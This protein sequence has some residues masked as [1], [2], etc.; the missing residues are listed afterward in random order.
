MNFNQQNLVNDRSATE[1]HTDSSQDSLDT[2]E[3]KSAE[4]EENNVDADAP[5]EKSK[6]ESTEGESDHKPDKIDKKKDVND[7]S[8]EETV[9]D[10]TIQENNVEPVNEEEEKSEDPKIETKSSEP[11]DKAD[12]EKEEDEKVS[13]ASE[14]TEEEEEDVIDEDDEGSDKDEKSSNGK[15]AVPLLDQPLETSGKRE[16]KNVQRFEEDFKANDKDSGKLEIDEG[17]GTALGEIPRIEASIVRFKNE[18]L[19]ILHRILFKTE[20]KT[21]LLKKNIKKFNGFVFKKDS[22][23]YKKKVDACKKLEVKSLKSLCEML[24]LEKKG[25]KDD[26][27]ERILDFLLEPKDSGKPVGGGRPK[28]AS[29]VRANNRGYSSH[30]DYSSDERHASRARRDKG[31]R[32]NLKDETSSDEEFKPDDASDGSDEKPRNVAKRKRGRAKKGSSE[33]DEASLTEGT[34][35][36]SDDEPKTK[37]RKS[38][39]K[40]NSK[41]KAG[42]GRGRGRP[43][44]SA[45]S[46]PARRGRGRKPKNVSESEEEEDEKMEEES[47]SEDEPLV[48]KKAKSSEP[49]TDDEIKTFIKSILEGANLE[50]ITMKTV[51]QRVYDN[52]PNFDLTARKKFIKATVKSLIST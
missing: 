24:D 17:S 13:A 19:K 35:D 42:R 44:K 43:A 31:K 3:I 6:E 37:R 48:K 50:E 47:S 7:T 1:N 34:S 4:T 29:A 15:K 30:D 25:N 12:V 33:E 22:D 14:K 23:D 8:D 11:N 20:G 5:A 39:T 9:E 26:I 40:V 51:C 10:K 16:R 46:T 36:E 38:I 2:K 45:T 52:Y 41:A 28:R 49:P 18:D 32:A 27:T 21:S